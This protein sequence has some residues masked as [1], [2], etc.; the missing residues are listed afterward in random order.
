MR[1]L[2]E[3]LEQARILDDFVETDLQTWWTMLAKM[4]DDVKA[5]VPTLIIEESPQESLIAKI[6]VFKTPRLHLQN[7]KFEESYGLIRLEDNGR[8]A[9]HI[10]PENDTSFVR[11][12]GKYSSGKHKIRFLFEK[13]STVFITSFDITSSRMPIDAGFDSTYNT[14]GWSSNDNVLGS[15]DVLIVDQNF[16]D[17]KNQS[18]FEI[19]LELDCDNRKISYVNVHTKNQ[20]E[21]HIDI[22]KCPFPWQ[23]RF[24][25]YSVGDCVRLLPCDDA[26]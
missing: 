19:D 5:I 21:L 12:I 22:T 6:D 20:R 16:R 3:R 2:A 25:L 13:S 23:I 11:G 26:I 7:E 17:M 14:Y 4:K 24:Y 18:S 8:V 10:G 1:D 9:V 15:S